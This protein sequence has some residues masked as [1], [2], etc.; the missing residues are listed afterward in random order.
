MTLLAELSERLAAHHSLAD[1]EVTA[2]ADALTGTDASDA[3]KTRFL[4]ALADKGETPAEVAAFA[5]AFRERAVNPRVERWAPHAIDIVGTGGD[6]VG[7]FNISS[8]VVFTLACAGVPVMK[9]GNRGVT[10]KCG[11]AD[12]LAGLGVNIEAPAEKLQDS[13]AQ[14]GFAFFY[15]PAYHPAFRHIAP[16]RKL[17]AA[18]GRRTI[19]NILGTLINP[20]RPAHILLGAFSQKWVPLLAEVHTLL[21]TRAGLSAHAILPPAADGAPRGIDE[22]TTTGP[23][24]VCGIGRLRDIDTLWQPGTPGLANLPRSPIAD[25]LGGSL[26]QNLAIVDALL[27][28]RG[29]AGLVDT[30]ALN[31]ATCLWI[32]GKAPSPADALPRA[33]ELLL[34]GAVKARIAATREFFEKS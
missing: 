32:T 1:E 7:A 14:L 18:Q 28:G 26:E 8:M 5:R 16:A 9:H 19:F 21:G 3:D 27:A 17:L 13:L 2:A 33:R 4:A 31:A 30:I 22:L 20:G 15:A 34:G 11:S 12:L 6:H 24:R 23:N 10:S 29:P 25:L